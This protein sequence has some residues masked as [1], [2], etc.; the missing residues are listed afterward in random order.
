METDLA[1][2][3]I[4][5]PGTGLWRRIGL[6]QQ[7]LIGMAVGAVLGL[8][9]G[10]RVTVLQPIG[11]LFLRLLVMAAIPLVFFNLLAGITSLTSLGTF[12]RVGLRIS[13]Y[14]LATTVLALVLGLAVMH[15]VQPGVGVRLTGEAPQQLGEVPAFSAILLDMVPSNVFAA[16]ANG[17]LPQVVV[18]ALL[19]GI[20]V[21][22]LPASVRTPLASAFDVLAQALRA[23]VGLVLYL[24]PIGIGALMAV[25]VHQHGGGLFGPLA[26]FIGAVWIAQALM[27]LVYLGLLALLTPRSPLDFLRK[28]APL[29][30]TTAATCSSMASLAQAIQVAEERLHLPRSIYSFTLALG[31]TMNQ[32]G[33]SITLAALLLFTAQAAGVEFSLASQITI[34]FVGILLS[35]GSAGIPGSAVVVA[36]LFVESFNLPVEIAAIVA[37]V[38]RLIDMGS[39]TVNVMGDLVGTVIVADLED[40]T[41]AGK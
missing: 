12:G 37:G 30:A 6:G 27:V 39:T 14:Y 8:T 36:L 11:E 28:T 41:P 22:T 10:E 38:Y 40:R 13:I 20:A 18:F 35:N 21:L 16:F 2:P 5:T 29:Y 34:V 3:A 7:I 23:L 15:V 17:K 25:T 4:G 19:L 31:A 26:K 1:P 24:A 9:A 32:N 33:T